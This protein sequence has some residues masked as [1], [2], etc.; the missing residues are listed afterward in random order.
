MGLVRRSGASALHSGGIL[1]DGEFEILEMAFLHLFEDLQDATRIVG[2]VAESV[3]STDEE[4]LL[5]D[6]LK[7]EIDRKPRLLKPFREEVE[8]HRSIITRSILRDNT[9]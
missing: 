5:G 2:V 3:Q 9:A 4:A 1:R 6:Q 8:F 7:A